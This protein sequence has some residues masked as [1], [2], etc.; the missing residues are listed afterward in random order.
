MHDHHHAWTPHEFTC[1]PCMLCVSCEL[2]DTM[3]HRDRQRWTRCIW[4]RARSKQIHR[5]TRDGPCLTVSTRF[6][7]ACSIRRTPLLQCIVELHPL[8]FLRKTRGLQR[9]RPRPEAP[10]HEEHHSCPR[11]KEALSVLFPS[12][13]CSK[14]SS[15]TNSSNTKTARS[16]TPVRC[17]SNR[18][19]SKPSSC[20]S[21]I[22]IN[23][24]R[25][26]TPRRSQTSSRARTRNCWSRTAT[27]TS[28][29]RTVRRRK[30]TLS[31]PLTA[32]GVTAGR[33]CYAAAVQNRT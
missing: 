22:N 23:T 5:T 25:N 15:C 18:T 13:T 31:S 4:R 27:S 9:T 6:L 1:H 28:K 21:S 14:P 20:T 30:R 33:L 29:T 32:T 16:T 17:P 8:E 26:T 12:S 10:G 7:P 19:C 24:A 2:I 11:R 3:D